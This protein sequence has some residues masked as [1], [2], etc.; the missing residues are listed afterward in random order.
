MSK[1]RLKRERPPF[2][3]L[4]DRILDDVRISKH[5]L[6]AYWVLCRHADAKAQCFPSIRRIATQTRLGVATVWRAIEEL[7]D[8]GYVKRQKRLEPGRREKAV[9]VYTILYRCSREEH[10]VSGGNTVFQG[11]NRTISSELEPTKNSISITAYTADF[12]TLWN[13]YPRKIAKAAAYRKWQATLKKGAD[14]KLLLQAVEAYAA[15]CQA[16]GRDPR[17]IK[18]ASTFFGPDEHWRDYS[19]TPAAEKESAEEVAAG[20]FGRA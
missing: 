15:E 12:E 10:G 4:E 20:Y 2:T 11:D 16:E 5:G 18:H 8:A 1:D 19:H 17:F 9:N 14:R 7:V 3:I 6:L 13:S